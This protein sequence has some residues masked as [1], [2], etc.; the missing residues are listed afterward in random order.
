MPL[1]NLTKININN[2]SF[3]FYKLINMLLH[4]PNVHTLLLASI[5]LSVR[6][7]K[8]IEGNETFRLVSKQNKIKHL[9]IYYDYLLRTIKMF[10]KLCPQVQHFTFNLS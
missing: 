4:T 7:V 8:S 2:G 3:D 1:T 10:I 5:S 9:T 6:E